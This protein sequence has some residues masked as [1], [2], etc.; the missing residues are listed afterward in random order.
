VTVVFAAYVLGTLAALVAFGD[1]SDHI[2][3][4][5]V[6][7]VAVGCAAVSTGL[8]LT[9]SPECCRRPARPAVD[10]LRMPP[11]GLINEM[12]IPCCSCR[13]TVSVLRSG[14]IAGLVQAG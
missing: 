10:S 6:L 7:A 12:I 1:L 4:R 9:A 8:F 14:R 5:K 2:G 11:T 13:V 3:R